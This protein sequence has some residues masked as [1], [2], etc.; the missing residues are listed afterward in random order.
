MK[1]I[2]VVGAG[3]YG[4]WIAYIL[5]KRGY[6]IEIFEKNFEIISESSKLNQYRVHRGYHY[7]K[8]LSTA[9]RCQ[10]NYN[11]FIN[12]FSNAIFSDFNSYYV[13]PKAMS[14]IS[15]YNFEKVCDLLNM[16]YKKENFLS[17]KIFNNNLIDKI[18]KVDEKVYKVKELRE[19]LSNLIDNKNIEIFLNTQVVVL[20]K[21]QLV[22]KNKEIHKFDYVFNAT[23]SEIGQF[24]TI[25]KKKL[26]LIY[27]LSE[28]GAIK[29][30]DK[31]K[32]IGVT[33]ID[34]NFFSI[35][36]MDINFHTISHVIYTHSERNNVNIYQKKKDDLNK[37]LNDMNVNKMIM[38]ASR[39]IPC[40]NEAEIKKSFFQIKTIS[41]FNQKNDSRPIII[42]KNKNCF[43]VIGSKIDNVFDVADYLEKYFNAK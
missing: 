6:K 32:K 27:V 41:N 2:A 31:I 4:C 30:P 16:P 19:K 11:K 15:A 42:E 3:I 8:S 7:L 13:I 34:G 36:P 21:N 33:L 37:N 43:N 40:L 5:S 24:N 10:V 12:F 29:V 28:I 35:L 20:N 14:N 17:S 26:S 25:S 18:Y 1:K 9:Y 38:D 39:F 22:T 23:Y